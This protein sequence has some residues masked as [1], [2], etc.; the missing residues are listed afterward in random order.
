M[1]SIGRCASTPS[2]IA[3]HAPQKIGARSP[4]MEVRGARAAFI[5]SSPCPLPAVSFRTASVLRDGG[6][7]D[8]DVGDCEGEG[9]VGADFERR[10]DMLGVEGG[11]AGEAAQ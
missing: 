1:A 3:T 11:G 10:L 9:A 8:A 2:A 6:A 5:R 4:M 7:G